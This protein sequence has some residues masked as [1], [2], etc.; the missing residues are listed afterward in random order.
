MI[1][2]FIVF[3]DL[4]DIGVSCFEVG[5][6]IPSGFLPCSFRILGGVELFALCVMVLAI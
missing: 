6:R 5:F 1:N 3:H 4:I 2:C